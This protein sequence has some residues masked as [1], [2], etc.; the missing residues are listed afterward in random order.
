MRTRTDALRLEVYYSVIIA[1]TLQTRKLRRPYAN[2]ARRV[3][4]FPLL[5]AKTEQGGI[6]LTAK[7]KRFSHCV[8]WLESTKNLAKLQEEC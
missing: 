2:L 1:R 8:D 6:L 7:R 4:A 3:L 5:L